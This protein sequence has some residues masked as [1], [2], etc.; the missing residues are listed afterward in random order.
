MMLVVYATVEP[1]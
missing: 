1:Y